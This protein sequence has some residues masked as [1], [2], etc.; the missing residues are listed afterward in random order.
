MGKFPRI[1]LF[2]F[3]SNFIQFILSFTKPAPRAPADPAPLKIMH[4]RVYHR[5]LPSVKNA[6]LN[7]FEYMKWMEGLL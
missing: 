4:N 1:T 6:I 7:I 5:N 2:Y 3:L